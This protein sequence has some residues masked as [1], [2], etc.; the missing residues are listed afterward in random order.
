MARLTGKPFILWTGVWIRLQ[1]FGHRLIYPLVRH[2]YRHSDAIVV[3]GEHVKRFLVGEGVRADR[4]FVAA[5]AVDNSVYQR[6]VNPAEVAAVRLK[7]GIGVSAKVVL[8]IGRLERE[9]GL[10]HLI[11]AFADIDDQDAILVLAGVGSQRAALESL[12]AVKGLTARIRF[13]GYLEPN[14]TVDYY[15]MAWVYVLPSVTTRMFKEPWGLVVNEAFNQGVPVIA[16]DAV[17]AAAGG[18]VQDG[19]NGSII[20]EGDAQSLSRALRRVLGDRD[21]RERMSGS[22]RETI[23]PWN[24]ERMISGFRQAVEFVSRK[25]NER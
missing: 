10:E 7:H 13:T 22:A 6:A 11:T 8:Y 15:A 3:Y 19:V 4:I 12:A 25:H 23:G 17:G 5:H 14:E 16:T 2:I 1:S 9:K 20:P 18:L 21:L 24:N